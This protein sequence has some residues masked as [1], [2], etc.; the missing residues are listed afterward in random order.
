MVCRGTESIEKE[1]LRRLGELLAESGARD[2]GLVKPSAAYSGRDPPCSASWDGAEPIKS[3]VDGAVVTAVVFAIG[4]GVGIRGEGLEA[5]G[6]GD[7]HD[8]DNGDNDTRSAAEAVDMAAAVG[9]GSSLL[10]CSVG[11]T[12]IG[13]FEGDATPDL[14]AKI[15]PSAIGKP[16]VP[17]CNTRSSSA[18]Q[19]N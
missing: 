3:E 2:A 19:R 17:P 5:E 15:G 16:C 6:M 4:V 1:L 8:G 9:Q 18:T 12:P 11:C 10:T 7:G 14:A 13:L